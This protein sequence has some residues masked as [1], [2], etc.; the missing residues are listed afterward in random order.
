MVLTSELSSLIHV[1]IDAWDGGTE[2][3]VSKANGKKQL[4]KRRREGEIVGS[5][6]DTGETILPYTAKTYLCEKAGVDDSYLKRIMDVE[7]KH[8]T[9]D[10]ADRLVTAMQ[11]PQAMHDGRLTVVPNPTWSQEHWQAWHGERGGCAQAFAPRPRVFRPRSGVREERAT[12]VIWSYARI[13]R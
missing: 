2:K 3:D 6:W 7:Y 11:I 8:T 13:G 5:Y 4:T 10:I 12:A 9:L 1:W